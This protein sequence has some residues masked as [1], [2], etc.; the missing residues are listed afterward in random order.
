MADGDSE[1]TVL[2]HEIIGRHVD[3]PDI[4]GTV[5]ALTIGRLVLET[6]NG[7]IE[8]IRVSAIETVSMETVMGSNH[9]P[10]TV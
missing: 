1:A 7:S 10:L 6:T 8:K 4:G 2:I 9:M 5:Q 3:F